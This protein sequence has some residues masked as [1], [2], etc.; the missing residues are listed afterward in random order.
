M[1]GVHASRSFC[2]DPPWKKKH[3]RLPRSCE[4]TGDRLKSSCIRKLR[5]TPAS[6]G[7]DRSICAID[8]SGALRSPMRADDVETLLSSQH[9]FSEPDAHLDLLVDA[10]LSSMSSKAQLFARSL[11]ARFIRAPLSNGRLITRRLGRLNNEGPTRK[12]EMQ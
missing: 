1:R 2:K 3:P 10:N 4:A 6:P 8:L 9:Q 12:G 11:T 5:G 7:R